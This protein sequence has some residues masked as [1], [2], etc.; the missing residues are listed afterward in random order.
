MTKEQSFETWCHLD[1]NLAKLLA[2]TNANHA[3]VSS[4]ISQALEIYTR[5][6]MVYS[7]SSAFYNYSTA[8]LPHSQQNLSK[9]MPLQNA[10]RKT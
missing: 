7:Y 10:K 5:E 2:M 4:T 1:S 6:N 3:N 9:D 8:L